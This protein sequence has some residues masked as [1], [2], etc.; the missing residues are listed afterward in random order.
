VMPSPKSI[1]ALFAKDLKPR[2]LRS[3]INII[4]IAVKKRKLGIAYI[5]QDMPF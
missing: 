2:S 4:L 5:F 1:F 3:E